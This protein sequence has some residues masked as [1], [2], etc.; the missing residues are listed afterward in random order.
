[1]SAAR[2]APVKTSP[3]V[4]QGPHLWG[5]VG[6]V[7]KVQVRSRLR[8]G[9]RGIRTISPSRKGKYQQGR[10]RTFDWVSLAGGQ[11][12][13]PSTSKPGANL[14]SSPWRASA[15]RRRCPSSPSSTA[16]FM[17]S[18]AAIRGRMCEARRGALLP[19]HG[20]EL[21]A[22]RARHMKPFTP[23]PLAEA[24]RNFLGECREPT[25]GMSCR[26]GGL[27]R[28]RDADPLIRETMRYVI[29]AVCR[30]PSGPAEA[31]GQGERRDPGALDSRFRA[32]PRE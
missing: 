31:V 25:A 14:T 24:V 29:L 11:R 5:A 1:M 7:P 27:E 21:A 22:R 15:L 30:H 17:A 19:R 8:A 10:S 26:S 20:D 2:V 32:L 3:Q 13:E 6:F 9:G 18:R 16:P 23:A 4:A 28:R 12:F